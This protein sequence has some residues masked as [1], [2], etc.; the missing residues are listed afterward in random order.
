MHIHNVYR[1]GGTRPGKTHSANR[2]TC[3][4]QIVFLWFLWFSPPQPQTQLQLKWRRA[5]QLLQRTICCTW[6]WRI[7]PAPL[8]PLL[9]HFSRSDTRPVCFLK[10]FPE[11]KP[12]LALF[13]LRAA[14]F[15]WPKFSP[16]SWVSNHQFQL[17]LLAL[18]GETFKS[19]SFQKLMQFA[20][21]QIQT[22]RAF[23]KNF[24]TSWVLQQNVS[25]SII[26]DAIIFK[27]TPLHVQSCFKRNL[28][29]PSTLRSD[30]LHY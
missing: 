22:E 10:Y 13:L 23:N 3:S 7:V 2:R 16:L 11:E 5:S 25:I 19:I 15:N 18:Q 9:F 28:F 24:W 1:Q 14:N 6:L 21:S 27:K 29:Q 8:L 17:A 12:P 20:H 4:T 26:C 30:S